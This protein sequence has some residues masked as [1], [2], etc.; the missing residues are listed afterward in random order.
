ML[1]PESNIS[2]MSPSKTNNL[3]MDSEDSNS[4]GS[5][6]LYLT[7]RYKI[8]YNNLLIGLVMCLVLVSYSS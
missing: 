8:Y 3:F 6:I 4:E 5:F 7:Y 1:F 2:Y